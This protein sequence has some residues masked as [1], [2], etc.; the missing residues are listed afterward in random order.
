MDWI[1][2]LI[3]IHI[4]II[5]SWISRFVCWLNG[6][7]VGQKMCIV[8]RFVIVRATIV[9]VLMLFIA[10][11]RIDILIAILKESILW[12][13]SATIHSV[14][15]VL[16]IIVSIRIGQFNVTFSTANNLFR[17]WNSRFYCFRISKYDETKFTAT[18][19]LSIKW[20]FNVFNLNR[21]LKK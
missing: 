11:I 13:T 19:S 5:I 18:I 17:Q 15:H 21:I 10:P 12:T 16:M 14:M 8:I 2:E 1:T 7:D 4:C 20:P 9:S 3:I 6:V